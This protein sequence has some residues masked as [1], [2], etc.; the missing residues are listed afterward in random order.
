MSDAKS[1][2]GADE[3]REEGRSTCIHRGPVAI[4]LSAVEIAVKRPDR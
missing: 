3:M 4:I 1:R 2:I